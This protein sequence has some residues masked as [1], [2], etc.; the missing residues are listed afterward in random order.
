MSFIVEGQPVEIKFKINKNGFVLNDVTE[1]E[2]VKSEMS[3]EEFVC[4]EGLNE[5][6]VSTFEFENKNSIEL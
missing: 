6:E 4:Y 3:E 5:K 1:I 2:T